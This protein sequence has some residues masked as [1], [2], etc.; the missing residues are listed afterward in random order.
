VDEYKD[1]K[2]NNYCESI[3][4]GVLEKLKEWIKSK[5]NEDNFK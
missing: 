5:E 4:Y 2:I 3:S 1:S